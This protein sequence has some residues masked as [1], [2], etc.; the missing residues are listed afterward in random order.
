MRVKVARSG[1][2]LAVRLPKQYAEELGLV[3]GMDVEL[4]REDLR[5]AI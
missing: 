3:A 4:E 5:L 1:N 2:S